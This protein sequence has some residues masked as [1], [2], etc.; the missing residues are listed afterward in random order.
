MERGISEDQAKQCLSDSKAAEKLADQV[1]QANQQ[2][3]IEGTPTFLLNG[4]KVDNVSGWPAL[5]TKQIGRASCR[6]SVCQY[7][8]I[9]VVAV[10]LKKTNINQY[11]TIIRIMYF[12]SIIIDNK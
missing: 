3:D 7:V 8:W 4:Q 6:E 12:A 2:Y 9:S 10:S 5:E 11:I 1:Q